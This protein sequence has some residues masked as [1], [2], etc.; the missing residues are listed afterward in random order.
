VIQVVESNHKEGMMK[1]IFEKEKIF[2]YIAGFLLVLIVAAGGYLLYQKNQS[3]TA[4]NSEVATQKDKEYPN[5]TKVEKTSDP[6]VVKITP[7]K[8][9]TIQVKTESGD[10]VSIPTYEITKD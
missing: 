6:D 10:T 7:S 4:S 9:D 5:E 1:N 3:D 2:I 8:D